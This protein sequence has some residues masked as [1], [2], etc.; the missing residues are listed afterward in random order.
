M[1]SF[2]VSKPLG[3]VL[4]E[5]LMRLATVVAAIGLPFGMTAT[6]AQAQTTPWPTTP[7][8]AICGNTS[9]LK[10][11]ETPP[12]G[13]IVVPAGDNSNVNFR[14]AG[15]TYWFA[16]GVHTLGTSQ[17]SQIRAIDNATYIGGSDASGQ[18]AIL[19]GQN[20]NRYAVGAHATGVTVKYLTIRNFGTGQSN[21]NEG[22]VN[23]DA[24]ANW[25]IEY[26][27]VVN[28]DGAGV[29]MG[30]GNVVRHNCM[31][32]NGQYGFS[33]YRPAIEGASAI[34]D[35]V[36]DHNEVTGNNTD[37]WES[38]E[39][40]CGCTGGGKFWDV[41]GARI[42]NNWIHDN[43]GPG[44][45]ADTN[46]IDF[47]IEGNLIENN[48]AEGI[49][50]ET[51]YNATIRNNAMRRNAWVKGVENQGSPGPAIY[52]SESGGDSRLQFTISGAASIR[53]YDNLFENNFAGVS[54]YEN[55]NRFCN[56]NGNT[57]K[58][59]CTPLVSPTLVPHPHDYEYP[60]PI[61]ASHP[62]Y[63]NVG[64]EPYRTNCRWSSQNI[65]VNRNEFIFDPAVVPCQGVTFCGVNA[66]HATG[67]DNMPW[68]PYTV[69]E[70]QNKVM[71]GANNHFH[72]NRYVGGWRFAKGYGEL[73]YP[74]VWTSSPFNQDA[75]S[76]FDG[77]PPPPPPPPPPGTGNYLD[78]DTSGLEGSIGDWQS[79]YSAQV[80]RSNQEAH[81]DSYSLRVDV[82]ARWWGIQFSNWPGFETPP[83]PKRVRYWAK[84]G[85]GTSANVT[86]RIRWFS[87]AQ[88]ILQTDYLPVQI[89]PQWEQATA[90]IQA[91]D[92][93]AS[94][95][96]EIYSST[97]RAGDVIYFD[98]FVV[99]DVTAP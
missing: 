66:L 49:F 65:E 16:P 11:P 12:P 44:L 24:G 26:N 59:Y 85:A 3:I 55:A 18:V 48:D 63:T 90:D 6:Q 95:F 45:W 78:A 20:L 5:W 27:T 92:G 86:M 34:T 70:I 37:D 46:N 8:A 57:S 14:L 7:P 43:R 79:W 83:G 80:T 10:G 81:G 87:A 94:V 56:S 53:I 64:Q 35:I 1:E 41:R 69:V 38:L 93:T 42:T 60:N 98:D 67:A 28:N 51:S 25:T 22:V 58:G 36:L 62:C 32:D 68:S 15:S 75:G 89:T 39:P 2:A 21:N 23:H 33:M 9:L 52:L 99:S 40:G 82:A 76:T 97:G 54:I 61:N 17:Y 71:F 19:D 84:R 88:Q 77:G 30:S 74:N 4:R 72:D 31:K 91:P 29:F 13:A 47:L 96:M 50:Y 73:V